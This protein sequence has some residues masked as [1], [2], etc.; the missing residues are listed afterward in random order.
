MDGDDSLFG[1]GGNDWL[2][3]GEGNDYLFG[4]D[5]GDNLFGVGGNDWLDAGDGNDIL[6]GM[7]GDDTLFGGAG[8]DLITGGAGFDTLFG[9][10]GNDTF[11]FDVLTSGLDS[12]IDGAFGPGA[13]DQIVIQNAGAINTFAEL[14]SQSVQSGSDVVIAFNATTGISIKNYTIAQLA[15]DDFLFA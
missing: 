10:V 1:V 14:M 6:F 8:D 15:A 7:N 4:M 2:D 3:A 11:V 13:G 9:G 5:G 12:I